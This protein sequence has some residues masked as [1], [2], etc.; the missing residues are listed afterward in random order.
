M[1]AKF[2]LLKSTA[3]TLRESWVTREIVSTV[4]VAGVMM[5]AM[6]SS[7]EVSYQNLKLHEIRI[8]LTRGELTRL[9]SRAEEVSLTSSTPQHS[10][11]QQ[12]LPKFH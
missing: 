3:E 5:E 11:I 12:G 8:V 10:K 7:L 4:K 6:G 2:M 9:S 1:D